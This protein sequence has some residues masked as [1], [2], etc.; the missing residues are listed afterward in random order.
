MIVDDIEQMLSPVITEMGYELWGCEYLAQGKHSLLRVYI[1]KA[2]GIGIADCERVSKEVSA[3]M[4]VEDPITGN[5]SMEVSS[6][7]IPRPLFKSEQY[8]RYQG[9]PVQ[10]K[11]YKPL[12]NKRKIAGL[13]ESADSNLLVLMVD[14]KPVEVPFINIVKANLMSE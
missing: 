11:L 7:G 5:Y 10:L 12:L 14:G 3:I 4:D 2:D 6:P 8:M 1:D 9:Q 13:I